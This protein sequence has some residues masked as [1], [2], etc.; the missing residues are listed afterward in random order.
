MMQEE[1]LTER[2]SLEIINSMINQAKNQFS[3]DGHLYLLWGWMVLICSIG[4][5]VLWHIFHYPWY[6][7]VWWLTWVL[8]VYQVIY[9]K[10]K[11]KRRRVKTYTEDILS[12]V[13]LA[14]FIPIVLF[15]AVIGNIFAAHGK[16]F[17]QFIDPIF[18]V[19]YGMPTFITGFALKFK[20]LW[21]GGIGCWVL[22][23]ISA[24]LPGD[25]QILALAPAMIIAWII[26]GYILRARYKKNAS[27]G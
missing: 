19:I 18:L 20:P 1:N 21:I 9:L 3:E 24:F 27:G 2:E 12:V 7:A 4:Q 8:V 6:Y 16:D 11:I 14:F 5:F 26:P 23:V 25:F 10:R 15:A 22:S 13:W 17:Y